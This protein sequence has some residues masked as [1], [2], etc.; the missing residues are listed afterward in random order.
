LDLANEALFRRAEFSRYQ[1]VRAVERDASGLSAKWVGRLRREFPESAEAGRAVGFWFGPVAGEWMPGDYNPWRTSEL[2]S[3]V[4]TGREFDSWVEDPEEEAAYQGI[5]A[6]RARFDALQPGATVA[7]LQ[8]DLSAARAEVQRLRPK[9]DPAHQHEVLAAIARLDSMA[10]VLAV[11]GV[12]VEDVANYLNDRKG[13]LPVAFASVIEFERRLR[14][15]LGVDGQEI[16][17]PMDSIV[18]WR[19]FL[20]AYPESPRAEAASFRMVRM[21]A[22]Q[23]RSR[24][25]IEAFRFP[26]AP[27][28][29]G[30]K[31]VGVVRGDSHGEPAQVLAAL[32]EHD[33]LFPGGRYRDDVDLLRAGA[34][35]DAG[36]F[37]DALFLIDRV[38]S[39]PAQRDLVIPATLQFAEIAQKLLE[40]ERRMEVVEAFRNHRG[41]VHWLERLV[42]G[43]TYLSRLQPMMPWL[44]SQLAG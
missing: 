11:P 16:P 26:E 27:I 34:Q 32:D 23:Q 21:I 19:E 1:N 12:R 39:N 33:V 8:R 7:S 40:P 36:N 5:E 37:S 41:A 3:A 4:M 30:Y 31:R 10:A 38:L 42:I 14:P 28:L 24:V 20:N 22:R 17:S 18:G 9:T 2:M 13:Q 44:R 25:A 15:V 29:W 43:G 35:I 6:Q